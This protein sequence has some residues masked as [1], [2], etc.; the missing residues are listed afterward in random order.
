MQMEHLFML[1]LALIQ[2]T[3]LSFFMSFNPALLVFVIESLWY[4]R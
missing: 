3:F 4:T 2:I 1:L